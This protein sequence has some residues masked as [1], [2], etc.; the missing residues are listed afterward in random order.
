MI[1][2]TPPIL[3]MDTPTSYC[4]QG[5]DDYNYTT[6]TGYG[7]SYELLYSITPPIQFLLSQENW[8]LK[9]T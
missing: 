6:N 4:T 1:T 2:I 7:Y 8:N 5:E 9:S 3:V